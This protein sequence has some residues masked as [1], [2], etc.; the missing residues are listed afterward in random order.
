MSKADASVGT[1]RPVKGDHPGPAQRAEWLLGSHDQLG[2]GH[3]GHAVAAGLEGHD[4]R[5]VQTNDARPIILFLLAGVL[6]TNCLGNER[7]NGP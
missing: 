7:N 5:L 1:F 2:T 4:G 6:V 3:T